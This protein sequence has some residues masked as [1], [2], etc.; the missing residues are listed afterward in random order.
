MVTTVSDGDEGTYEM[1][2]MMAAIALLGSTAAVAQ[3]ATA[4]FPGKL[5]KAPLPGCQS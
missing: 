1:K 3:V 2:L 5:A 4:A